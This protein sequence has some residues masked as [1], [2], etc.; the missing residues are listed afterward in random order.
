MAAV[1]SDRGGSA[2]NRW[3][4]EG[5]APGGS[6]REDRMPAQCSEQDIPL[7]QVPGARDAVRLPYGA[8]S[9]RSKPRT[10]RPPEQ[11]QLRRGN[12]GGAEQD[13][14]QA[15]AD[16]RRSRFVLSALSWRWPG[17]GLFT[18]ALHTVYV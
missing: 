8:R 14:P 18:S 15:R 1:H 13:R 6:S 7:A 4:R 10:A 3:Q 12:A 2:S 9:A 5:A 16:R 11:G 17:G